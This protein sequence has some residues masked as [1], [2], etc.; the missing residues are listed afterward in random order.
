MLSTYLTQMIIQSRLPESSHNHTPPENE[1]MSSKKRDKSQKEI[2]SSSNHPFFMGYVSFHPIRKVISPQLPIYF[3]PFIG[4]I[5]S[6]NPDNDRQKGP[7]L[8]K[9]VITGR[10]RTTAEFERLDATTQRSTRCQRRQNGWEISL[11]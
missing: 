10:S 11:M 1:R 9:P 7:T 6:N 2:L 8:Q 4:I 3:R 5:T